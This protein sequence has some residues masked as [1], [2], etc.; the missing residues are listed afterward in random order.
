MTYLEK[1]NDP[2]WQQK[3]LRIM[4][5]D[6]WTCLEC[7]DKKNQLQVHHIV[8]LNRDPWDY[9]DYLFQT[10]CEPCH[11]ERQEL[12]DKIVNAVKMAIAPVPTIRL[13]PMA[14]E[15]CSQ[16]MLRIEVDK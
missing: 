13:I 15:I 9:P 2:R 14:L 10:F 3:R 8:Y 4:E 12:T 7:A 6:N 16:A 11:K 1:L 5:R